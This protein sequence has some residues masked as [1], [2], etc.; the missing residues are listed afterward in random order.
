[1]FARRSNTNGGDIV[2]GDWSDNA[3]WN[4]VVG[5]RCKVAVRQCARC[6]NPS[7]CAIRR[8]GRWHWWW[9]SASPQFASLSLISNLRSNISQCKSH[10]LASIIDFL[11]ILEQLL[12]IGW[13]MGKAYIWGIF[14]PSN[15]SAETTAGLGGALTLSINVHFIPRLKIIF[16]PPLPVL[17]LYNE[18][19][20]HRIFLIK[21]GHHLLTNK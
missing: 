20:S 1:M 11:S 19:K 17:C 3:K 2:T 18:P 21:S 7:Q 13:W 6:R 14:S 4:P 15:Q 5:I 12:P 16:T 8:C 9:K 10:L